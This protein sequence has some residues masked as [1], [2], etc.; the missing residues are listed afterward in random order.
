[1]PLCHL[2]DADF[3]SAAASGSALAIVRQSSED[4]ASE[5]SEEAGG[6]DNDLLHSELARQILG[7]V[8][9]QL[10]SKDGCCTG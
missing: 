5:I 2:V 8:S 3:I 9:I 10:S 4:V 1:M 6:D 7:L